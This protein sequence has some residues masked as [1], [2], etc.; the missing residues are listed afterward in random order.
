L[1][2]LLIPDMSENRTG[3][4]HPDSKSYSCLKEKWRQRS[5]TRRHENEYSGDREGQIAYR[6][7]PPH[8]KKSEE[9]NSYDVTE[10]YSSIKPR[11]LSSGRRY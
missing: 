10:K 1:P 3:S 9:S 4:A 7:N 8:L 2:L 11:K 5:K 6:N